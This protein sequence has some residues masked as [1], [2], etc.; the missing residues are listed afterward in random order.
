MRRITVCGIYLPYRLGHHAAGTCIPVYVPDVFP[1]RCVCCLAAHSLAVCS[2]VHI[3]AIYPGIPPV[4][5]LWGHLR[6]V[7]AVRVSGCTF[8]CFLLV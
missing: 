3:C 7:Q 4:Y 5:F 8:E 6:V 1:M 2:C